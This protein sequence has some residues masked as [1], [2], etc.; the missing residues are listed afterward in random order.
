MTSF[1]P[2]QRLRTKIVCTLGPSIQSLETIR[3]MVEGG[4]S[5]ARLN[6]S[7]GDLEEH[8]TAVES[9]RSVAREMDKAVGVLVDVPGSKYRTGPI[10]AGAVDFEPGDEVFLTS[11]LVNLT[12]NAIPVLPAGIHRDAVPGNRILL[13]D[14]IVTLRILRIEGEDAICEALTPGRITE[15]RGV[16]TPGVSPSQPFPDQK[17][18]RALEF[19]AAQEVDFV[20]LSTVTSADQI[21]VARQILSKLGYQ[22]SVFS[23]I[24]RAEAIAARDSILAASDGIM[25]ARGDLGTEVPLA[26]VPILQK[27]WIQVCNQLGK[28]VITATQML[29]SMMSH[30]SPT[31]AEVADVANAVFDGT[32]ALMLSGETSIGKYPIEAVKVMTEVA[33]EAESALPYSS[34]LVEKRKH[35]ERQTDDAIAYDSCQTAHQLKASLIVAFTES[36]STAHR[37]SKYR[38]KTPILALTPNRQ[39]QRSLTLSWGV[40][41]VITGPIEQVDD[42]F[43][44]AQQAASNLQG[45]SQGDCVVLVA[46]LPIGVPG[47]T[48]LLR[49]LTIE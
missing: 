19:A 13:A 11:R 17:A 25:I 24:E 14:G 23:K 45:I 5:V 15:G 3:A 28:P 1:P 47:G 44:R 35:L 33:V 36:G 6:F 42:F 31:R 34:M 38:P 37:V 22:G 49:V 48:N 41:P 9:V 21:A 2:A 32:D 10:Q 40:Q 8:T 43:Q 39:T 12:G 20:A 7:H 30:P 29:E 18:S 4:M 26:R 16:S 27:E 46:G